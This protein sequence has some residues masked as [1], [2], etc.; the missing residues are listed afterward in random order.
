MAW[1]QVA[2]QMA[3]GWLNTSVAVL[4]VL[5][6][7]ESPTQQRWWWDFGVFWCIFVT[8][9]FGIF[10]QD[11]KLALAVAISPL[12]PSELTCIGPHS[13]HPNVNFL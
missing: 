12:S 1:H 6:L 9:G 3:I 13:S 4:W 8:G 2:W 5:E 7:R 11:A 10:L